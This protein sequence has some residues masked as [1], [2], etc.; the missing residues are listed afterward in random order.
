MR[1]S[2]PCLILRCLTRVLRGAEGTIIEEPDS[3]PRVIWG[4]ENDSATGARSAKP[5]VVQPHKVAKTIADPPS[6]RPE[7][8][9]QRDTR[10]VDLATSPSSAPVHLST[11]VA[12]LGPIR[13]PPQPPEFMLRHSEPID[14][15]RLMGDGPQGQQHLSPDWPSMAPGQLPTPELVH[16]L[17]PELQ[18]VLF[19]QDLCSPPLLGPA[20]THSLLRPDIMS[21]SRS[22]ATSLL[23]S[24]RSSRSPIILEELTSHY[25][26]YSQDPRLRT[27][28][29]D[30]A[31]Q[32]R[33][34]QLQQGLLPTPPDSASPVWSS[35]FSPYQGGLL[36]PELLAAAGLSQLHS[37]HLPTRLDQCQSVLR[38]AAG[39]QNNSHLTNRKTALSS[40]AP[41]THINGQKLPPRLAAEYARRHATLEASHDGFHPAVYQHLSLLHDRPDSPSPPKVPPNT[42]YGASTSPHSI[43]RQDHIPYPSSL[44]VTSSP[45]S[46]RAPPNLGLAN[47]RSVPLSK[48]VQRRLS[49]VPEEDNAP[50][51]ECGRTHVSVTQNSGTGLH[52]YLS[53]SVRA[54][55]GS[56]L[57][58]SLGNT[59][60]MRYGAADMGDKARSITAGIKLSSVPVKTSGPVARAEGTL[61]KEASRRQGSNV[62]TDGGRRGESGR[63]RGQ[64]RGGRVKKGRGPGPSV[65]GAERIDGGLV[66]KS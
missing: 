58:D 57:A 35:V 10:L 7:A 17:S 5:A 50:P 61:T 22:P 45:T 1:F 2:F 15:G 25:V 42:P 51:A 55:T 54:G 8:G 31:H 59:L 20:D 41:S 19:A 46:P 9:H 6:L 34:Q 36:S 43:R 48:L 39:V 47:V 33:Q 62:N 64:K 3:L 24:L 27:S 60:G 49:T 11:S 56:S 32:Y 16:D 38:S 30:I 28:A 66:V 12:R 21:S 52:L 40:L 14:L 23:D 18:G 63:G 29:L 44:G 13:Q 65:H 26:P 37:K 53:P 4:L